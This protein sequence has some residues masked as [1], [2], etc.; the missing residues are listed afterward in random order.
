LDAQVTEDHDD[1]RRIEH[2]PTT[3]P[4]LRSAARHLTDAG[5]TPRDVS[6]ALAISEMAVLALLEHKP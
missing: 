3:L 5:Y 4:E 6:A 2:R 1:Q